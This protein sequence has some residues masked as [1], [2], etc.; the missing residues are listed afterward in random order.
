[1]T[2]TPRSRPITILA[3]SVWLLTLCSSSHAD[4]TLSLTKSFVEKYSNRA[5]I[6][7]HCHVDA[8]PAH[9]HAAKDDGDMHIAVRCDEA[10]FV[11]VSEIVNARTEPTAMKHARDAVGADP[12]NIVGAL[13]FWPEHASR[14]PFVQSDAEAL[15]TKVDTTNPPTLMPSTERTGWISKMWSMGAT[16]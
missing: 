5:T 11:G 2:D 7:D 13:R 9:P 8:A 6:S 12:V 10:Q 3:T 15:A 16:L 4:V 1:M 14:D